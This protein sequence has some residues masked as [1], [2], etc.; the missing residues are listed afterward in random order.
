[1]RTFHEWHDYWIVENYWSFGN[2]KALCKKHNEIFG[3]SISHGV[4]V[5]HCVKQLN[6]RRAFTEEQ[7]QWLKINYPVMGTT[8]ATEEFNKKFKTNRTRDTIRTHCCKKKIKCNCETLSKR[9]RSNAKKYA[10]VGTITSDSHGYLHIKT[11]DEFGKRSSNWELYHRWVWEKE[12]GKVPDDCW[13]IFLD[14]DRTNCDV[15]NLALIPKKYNSL[16]MVYGLKSESKEITETAIKWCELYT[17]A[18]ENNVIEKDYF[19]EW[20]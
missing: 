9:G 11:K 16:M 13:L 15:S 18:R 19:W 4:F 2:T 12:N 1:M 20:Q 17:V 5:M 3:T 8:I 7:E 6:L 14:N 10:P